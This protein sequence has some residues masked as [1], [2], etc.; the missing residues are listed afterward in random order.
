MKYLIAAGFVC[1]ILFSCKS[2]SERDFEKAEQIA[3]DTANFTTVQWIDSIVSFGSINKGEKIS[4]KFRCKN[5]GNK[6][7][8]L[9]NVR[10]GCGCTVADYTKE[11]I[12]PG[13]EGLITAAF[14]S[15]KTGATG[16]VDKTIIVSANILMNPVYLHFKGTIN[17]GGS[18][19]K[20][21]EPRPLPNNK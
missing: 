13:T 21:A 11:P 20:V 18:N 6:P 15:N 3:K 10:P 17:G 1:T 5:T 19:D 4:I 9:A 7:L 2:K 8:I 14:D 12:M 16:E